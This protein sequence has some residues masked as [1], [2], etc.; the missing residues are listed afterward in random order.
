MGLEVAYASYFLTLEHK[1][2]AF[3][4]LIEKLEDSLSVFS[5]AEFDGEGDTFDTANKFAF[6][7]NV[8]ALAEVKNRIK[9]QIQ[10]LKREADLSLKTRVSPYSLVSLQLAGEVEYFL[11]LPAEFFSTFEILEVNGKEVQTLTTS[12]P[13]YQAIEGLKEG[14]S[15][16]LKSG[17]VT[18]LGVV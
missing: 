1:K 12:A 4:K 9:R 8:S 7:H 6:L 5:D 11:I 15:V 2:K 14:E 17:S 10:I 18:V 13:L 16:N 3:N